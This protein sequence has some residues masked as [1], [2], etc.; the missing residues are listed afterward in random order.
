MNSETHSIKVFFFTFIEINRIK[1]KHFYHC[2]IAREMYFV[3]PYSY[4][5]PHSSTLIYISK[6]NRSRNQHVL[7]FTI[8]PYNAIKY[9]PQWNSPITYLLSKSS[10]RNPSRISP[11]KRCL[12]NNDWCRS[13]GRPL[14]S[15]I[16]SILNLIQSF[17]PFDYIGSD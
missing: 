12:E 8:C 2:F 16:Q 6:N 9:P 3:K 10:W 17:L 5:S 1:L 11:T 7:P 15:C 13:E 4:P 14:L